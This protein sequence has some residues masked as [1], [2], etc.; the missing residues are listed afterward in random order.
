MLELSISSDEI[1]CFYVIVISAYILITDNNRNAIIGVF[2]ASI[3]LFLMLY[4]TCSIVAVT[5][6]IA[7]VSVLSLLLLLTRNIGQQT[8]LK[9]IRYVAYFSLVIAAI[10]ELS[11]Y[12][13]D[14][15]KLAISS[16]NQISELTVLV[17]TLCMFVMSFI[18]SMI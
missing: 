4:D 14:I 12:V 10:Y 11:S 15:T 17:I 8:K 5:I 7:Y 6:G 9:D 13:S 16:F 3:A 2:F 1:F 18:I